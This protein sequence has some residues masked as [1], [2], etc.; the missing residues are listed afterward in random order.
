MPPP[1]VAVAVALSRVMADVQSI[2]KTQRNTQQNYNFRGIDAVVNAVGPVLRKHG[3]VVLPT[4]VKYQDERYVTKSGTA[5]KG[6][7]LKIGF[8]FYGPR[9]DYIDAM[10]AGEASDSGDKATPKAHSV[11]YRTLLLQA[12]CIPTDEPDPDSLSHDRAPE[13]HQERRQPAADVRLNPETQ[14]PRD[15]ATLNEAWDKLLG[16]GGEESSRTREWYM[17]ETVEKFFAKPKD[18]MTRGE[19]DTA[20]QKLGTVYLRLLD[21]QDGYDE[22]GVPTRTAV[23]AAIASAFEGLQ[24]EGPPWRLGRDEQELPPF[25]EWNRSQESGTVAEVDTGEEP[26]EAESEAEAGG[27]TVSVI[28]GDLPDEDIQFGDEP[29]E[30]AKT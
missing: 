8:R 25:G 3:V 21:D 18:E 28:E 30:E 10:T 12:L 4:S 17:T 13:Q 5:M 26:P 16:F 11:A 6:V 27:E 23:Q 29:K 15:W 9:G 14:A 22:F 2:S 19:R 24:V 7:V 1:D 20:K